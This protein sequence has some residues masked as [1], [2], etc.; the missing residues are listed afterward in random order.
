MK[1]AIMQ[2][3]IFPYI[4]YFQMINAVDKFVFYDDVN[5]I[6]QG[7]INRNKIMVSGTDHLFTVPLSKANSFTPIKDTLIN[8][9]LYENWKIKFLQT[10]SQSYKNAPYFNVI[11]K[12]VADI[13]NNNCSSISDLAISSIK[14]ISHYLNLKTDFIIS[15]QS[16]QNKNL[17]RQE[18]L[19]DICIQEKSMHYINAFGGQ[20]LYKKQDFIKRG[21][22][23]DFIKTLPLEY[24]QFKNRF[25]P[26]LSFIDVLMFNNAD[27]INLL[28]T[29]YEFIN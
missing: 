22:K 7:W 5:F 11:Y 28:L 4:G 8:E 21:I 6:K 26:N 27:E 24:K 14:A 15:S 16:Y 13:M 2:P 3:Y 17:E 18:R 25:I 1:I 10:I 23:L 29:Q 20:E 12:L 9:K 19:F